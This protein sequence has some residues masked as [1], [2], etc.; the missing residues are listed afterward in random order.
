MS[1]GTS[2]ILRTGRLSYI[3]YGQTGT[4]EVIPRASWNSVA[5]RMRSCAPGRS[6]LG[7]GRFKS[8][9]PRPASG[10]RAWPFHHCRICTRGDDRSMRLHK[11]LEDEA[12]L[13]GNKLRLA[14]AMCDQHAVETVADLREQCEFGSLRDIFPQ[15]VL[16]STVRRALASESETRAESRPT[17][18]IPK[19]PGKRWDFFLSH[20]VSSGCV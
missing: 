19:P 2:T 3:Y 9:G 4:H 6:D 7:S 8:P 14:I 10:A 12:K 20:K 17:D 1:H 18:R 15:S 5:G 11:W 16:Y 13:V